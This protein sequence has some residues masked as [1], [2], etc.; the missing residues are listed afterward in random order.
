MKRKLKT[1]NRRLAR[2]KKL[3]AGLKVI[4][5]VIQEGIAGALGVVLGKSEAMPDVGLLFTL[6]ERRIASLGRRLA[7]CQDALAE[8]E[9]CERLRAR[10]RDAVLARLLEKIVRLRSLVKGVFGQPGLE[11]L[12]LAGTT[13]RMARE[14]LQVVRHVIARLRDPDVTLPEVA[15]PYLEIDLGPVTAELEADATDLQAALDDRA[16]ASERTR[17]AR[18]AKDE[19]VAEFD[20]FVESAAILARCLCALAGRRDLAERVRSAT[21]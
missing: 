2:G 10:E 9:E 6:L 16:R 15:S 21:R 1:I 4:A 17:A 12:G 13:P 8:G 20:F 7:V 3:G 14:L 18:A 5:G 19:T 11:L